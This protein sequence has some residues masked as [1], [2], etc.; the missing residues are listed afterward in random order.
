MIALACSKPPKGN[1]VWSCRQLAKKTGLG[2]A[3]IHRILN[4]GQ[5]KP[6]EVKYW[7]GRSTDLSLRGN[8]AAMMGLYLNPPENAVVLAVDEKR[9]RYRLWIGHNLCLPMREEAKRL[10]L[11]TNG[12]V[13]PVF[14]LHVAV[15][16]GNIEG[17]VWRE[18]VMR[19]FGTF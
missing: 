9:V 10:T 8:E 5:M 16:K 7:C 15:H 18:A 3:T 4:E 14:L 17:A 12:M 13:L 1:T 6:H 11:L 19:N 2:V